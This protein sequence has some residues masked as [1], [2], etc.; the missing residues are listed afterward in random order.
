MVQQRNDKT[1]EP[2]P[3]E[4][5]SLIRKLPQVVGF[6]G[7]FI[8]CAEL[9]TVP[10]EPDEDD[11][12]TYEEY[13]ESYDAYAEHQ[14]DPKP[15]RLVSSDRKIVLD[16]ICS[17][18]RWTINNK[19]YVVNAK[20]VDERTVAFSHD[21]EE[22]AQIVEQEN[23][24]QNHVKKYIDGISAIVAHGQCW[25]HETNHLLDTLNPPANNPASA[26]EGCFY[27]RVLAV[28]T[29]TSIILLWIGHLRWYG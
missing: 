2:S 28:T 17:A 1:G 26:F 3:N 7:T 29:E 25:L 5:D 19:L 20:S 8:E 24:H 14:F 21:P 9:P 23:E 27:D 16:T 13:E 11:F 4:L 18:M 6:D 10:G 12:E 15:W 22:N